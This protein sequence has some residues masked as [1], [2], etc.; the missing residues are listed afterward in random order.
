[1]ARTR[2]QAHSRFHPVT[3]ALAI[4]LAS[5]HALVITL[6]PLAERASGSVAPVHAEQAGTSTHHAHGDLCAVCAASHL[7]APLPRVP[8]GP[9]VVRAGAQPEGARRQLETAAERLHVQPR[10]PPA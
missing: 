2:P 4:I 3:R 9:P 7:V 5:V 6:A 1:M 8:L 10:A